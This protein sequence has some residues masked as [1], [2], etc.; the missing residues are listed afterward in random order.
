MTRIALG[1]CYDGSAYR[2][3]QAQKGCNTIQAAVEEALSRVANHPIS[4]LGAGRT[5]AGVHALNQIIHFDTTAIRTDRAWLLGTNR[6]LPSDI[7]V[8]WVRFVNGDFH[9]RYSA[10]SRC[11]RYVLFNQNIRPAL[12]RGGAAWHYRSLDVTRMHEAA[13]CLVGEH[14]FSSFRAANCQSKT[15]FRRVERIIV[16][17]ELSLVTVEIEAN[18]FLHHMVRNIVGVL[19]TVGSGDKPI[20]WVASVLEARDRQCA[21]ITAA[22]EGLYLMNVSYPAEYQI[23]QSSETPLFLV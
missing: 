10:H 15:P 16:S 9:A 23:P 14:D 4:V 3:F 2:G 7:R 21:G 6:E 8:T 20:E 17:R 12:L 5:D 1:L 19:L 13:Q 22:S 18:A 11:Y